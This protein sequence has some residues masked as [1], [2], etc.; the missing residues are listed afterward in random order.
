MNYSFFIKEHFNGCVI[1]AEGSD[2]DPLFTICLTAFNEELTLRTSEVITG[3]GRIHDWRGERQQFCP[4]LGIQRSIEKNQLY[5]IQAFL[6]V[7]W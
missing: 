5:K 6:S 7:S 3:L 1:E 2:V 4:S